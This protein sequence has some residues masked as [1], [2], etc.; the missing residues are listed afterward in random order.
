M[1][2]IFNSA[3]QLT[4]RRVRGMSIVELLVVTTVIGG[5]A[6]ALLVRQ[7]QI[8]RQQKVQSAVNTISTIYDYARSLAGVSRDFTGITSASAVGTSELRVIAKNLRYE[9]SGATGFYTD[10]TF[11]YTFSGD[12]TSFSLIVDTRDSAICASLGA[13]LREGADYLAAAS[14]LGFGTVASDLGNLTPASYIYVP[15]SKAIDT[16][17]LTAACQAATGRLGVTYL[18]GQANL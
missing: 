12:S 11:R 14:N 13:A 3:Q 4:T 6:A 8:D 5:A 18:N 10:G 1:S 16:Q 17:R 7:A 2:S 15:D 9:G